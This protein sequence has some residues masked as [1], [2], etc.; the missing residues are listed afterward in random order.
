LIAGRGMMTS[1]VN[2]WR[3]GQ[4][5]PYNPD[6][7]IQSNHPA[8]DAAGGSTK[9]GGDMHTM[10]H[11]V[12][13]MHEVGED[14]C[15][16]EGVEQVGGENG[17]EEPAAGGAHK[18]Y[19]MLKKVDKPLHGGTKHSK[20]SATLHLYNLKC[21]GGLSNNIFSDF[22]EFINQLL[23]ACDDTLP[24]N[25][26]ETKKYLSDMGLGYENI[27][28]SYNDC[29]LFWKAN[30]EFDSCTECGEDEDSQ[31]IS[32]RKKRSVKVL[33]WFPL[34]PRLQRLFMSK[35]CSLYQMACRR[36]H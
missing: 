34:I 1:Y 27:P 3:H 16:P 22:L 26:Y 36:P 35:H 32:S 17:N 13:S 20:L 24:A 19:D 8:I 9:Q 25:T 12:F 31:P 7:A 14:N 28:G 23:P 11:D 30:G 6:V 4:T 2:W 29:I 18:Y 21:V 10:W 33:R 5:T 15:G